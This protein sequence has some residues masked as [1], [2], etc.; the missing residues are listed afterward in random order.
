MDSDKYQD[1][2][3]LQEA[4]KTYEINQIYKDTFPYQNLFGGSIMNKN[5]KLDNNKNSIVPPLNLKK[6]LYQP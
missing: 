1:P 6:E 4:L 3:T 2:Y 5:S